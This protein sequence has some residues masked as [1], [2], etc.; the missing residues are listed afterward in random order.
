MCGGVTVYTALKRS[1]VKHGQWVVV[2]GAGGG[3]GHLAIQY[4]KACGTKVI[5][6]DSGAKK[7]LCYELG[8]DHFID[9]TQYNSENLTAEVQRLAGSLV[10]LVMVCSASKRAYDQAVSFLGFRGV[11]ACLGVPEGPP[12][13]IQ[14]AIVGDFV[15]KELTMFGNPTPS[16]LGKVS[17]S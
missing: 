12:G 14:G 16:K 6:L 15:Q 2:S 10:K 13:P 8:A 9:F 1:G 4:A 17:W 7:D 5:A 3:L 11:L